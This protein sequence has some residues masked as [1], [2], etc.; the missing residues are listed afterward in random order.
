M[1][2]AHARICSIIKNL[3]AEGITFSADKPCDYALLTQP[4]ERELIRFIA[5]FPDEII[6]AAKNYDPAR[7]TRYA[8]DLA[9]QYHKFYNACRVKDAEPALYTARLALCTATKNVIANVLGM[10]KIT[11]PQSM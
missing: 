7:V 3:A 2:Y 1:Q 5:N 4:S 9:T 6:A 10:L 11:V 8:I